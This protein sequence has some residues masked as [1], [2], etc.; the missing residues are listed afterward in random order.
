MSN[1]QLMA[2]AN[3]QPKFEKVR[4]DFFEHFPL[5]WKMGPVNYGAMIVEWGFQPFVDEVVAVYLCGLALARLEVYSENYS[6]LHP[7]DEGPD[8]WNPLFAWG[9]VQNELESIMPDVPRLQAPAE[10]KV[11]P[12]QHRRRAG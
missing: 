1:R 2:I 5:F 6:K 3:N 10:I 9:L 11:R 8:I 4:L 7:D 12:S